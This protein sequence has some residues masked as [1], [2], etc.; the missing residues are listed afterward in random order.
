[1]VVLT[2]PPIRGFGPLCAPAGGA[3]LTHDGEPRRRLVRQDAV[4]RLD[5]A[6]QVVLDGSAGGGGPALG[7][8]LTATDCGRPAGRS[9][10]RPAVARQ[11]E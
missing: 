10:A 9:R 6:G 4:I 7:S 11:A 8:T 5:G 1:M 2:A 3:I